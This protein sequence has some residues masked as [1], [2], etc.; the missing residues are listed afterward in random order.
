MFRPRT[1]GAGRRRPLLFDILERRDL[2]A[3]TPALLVQFDPAAGD[4][5]LFL[6]QA[7]AQQLTAA[8]TDIP[9][10][11]RLTG[12][13][14][15]L[16]VYQ[17]LVTGRAGV[18][19][20]EWEQTETVALD[21]NDPK[22][23]DGTLWG[24]NG[25][26]GIKAPQAWDITTGTTAVVLA[27]IDT[28]VDYT[29][30]DLYLNIWIN[31]G[32]IPPTLV[33]P[34]NPSRLRDLDRDGLITFYDLNNAINQ[35]PGKI[36]D[37]NGNGRID[38]GDILRPSASGGWANGVSDNG[39]GYVDDLIGWDFFNNDNNPMDDNNHGTHTTGTIAG[40]GNNAVG[41]AGVNWRAQIMVMKFLGAGGS[42]SD[43][44]A[45][46]CIRY[47]ADHGARISNNSWGGGG[48]SSTL[49]NA[50]DYARTKNHL[51]VAAAGN[52][53]N[54]N[55]ANPFYPASYNL[56]NVLAVASITS[57]GDRSSF[58]N[59]G[60]TSVDLGAPGSGIYSTV[61]GGYATFSGTS[62]ATP[63][64]AGTAALVLGVNPTFTT[65][66]IISRIMTTVTPLSSMNGI[67][68]SGGI[69]NAYEAVKPPAVPDLN[70]S[71]GGINGPTSTPPSTPF[72]ISR[73]YNIINTAVTSNFTISYTRSLNTVY[74]DADDVVMGSETISNA[75]DKSV[76]LHSGNSPSFSISTP[77]T[78]YLFAKLDA[79]G[80]VAETDETNN[81][82]QAPRALVVSGSPG[83]SG[84]II[85]DGDPGYSDLGGGWVINDLPGGY[86]ADHRSH[87]AGVG[88]AVA[89][90]TFDSS[91]SSA[92]LPPTSYKVYV[93]WVP[94]ANRASNAPYT[95]YDNFTALGTIQADQR[96]NPA[97]D[98][99]SGVW[100][101]YLGTFNFVSGIV[102][103]RLT[104]DADGRVDADA[105]RIAPNGLPPP[106]GGS[107]P[108]AAGGSA[109]LSALGSARSGGQ[110]ASRTTTLRPPTRNQ[111][112]APAAAGDD[113]SGRVVDRLFAPPTNQGSRGGVTGLLGSRDQDDLLAA[114]LTKPAQIV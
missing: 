3:A 20:A 83:G 15:N 13:G 19:Y 21:P 81:V 101:K 45:A 87:A 47:A 75:A 40:I 104:D 33:D 84:A 108:A 41:V 38:A 27:D 63:H 96:L 25:T 80:A 10:L 26:Y 62:M 91:I 35:G 79:G 90:W 103:V 114:L 67:T 56:S 7:Q 109:F 16:S 113:R 105:V 59:Y 9:G 61:V 112:F 31:Q 43:T 17:A 18:Q 72:T 44:G 102:R 74:G 14:S 51:F 49:F 2:L 97:D 106:P 95:V 57:T 100:W 71:R 53:N 73:T 11:V 52:A 5:D 111:G 99:N 36:T 92:A 86:L 58:S 60:K 76:G 28:G 12:L 69:V 77:G 85:D 4:R 107:G 6:L 66:Q 34:N 70:W 82:A 110:S 29:H 30:P 46:Q 23:V 68:V 1:K 42:G 64:V 54:N 37:L 22:Y 39:D 24:M 88:G 78:Y 94:G 89:G 50:I 93:T 98:F 8:P 65:D 55:D 32:E 48:F